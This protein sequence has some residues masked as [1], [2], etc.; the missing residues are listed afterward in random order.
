MDRPAPPAPADGC[1]A[2]RDGSWIMP[3]VA[4]CAAVVGGWGGMHRQALRTA[5]VVSTRY[6]FLS[7][8]THQHLLDLDMLPLAR[9]VQRRAVEGIERVHVNTL[10]DEPLGDPLA[11]VKCG[12][13]QRRAAV[14]VGDLRALEAGRGE[15]GDGRSVS[16]GRGRQEEAGSACCVSERCDGRCSL[17]FLSLH[18]LL[19]LF[20]VVLSD[21]V[22]Q[23]VQR[24]RLLR[25]RE[26]GWACDDVSCRAPPA[27]SSHS[28]VAWA[29]AGVQ[30]GRLDG[31][32]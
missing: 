26:R 8:F 16:G 9:E 14:E 6:R 28:S 24:L 17:D 5:A 2:M 25:S 12:D 1:S 18:C 10:A 21:P 31:P 27:I 7:R 3:P 30:Q 22:Q 20:E 4:I 13:V 11:V 32:P 19:A 23:L 29:R 15:E